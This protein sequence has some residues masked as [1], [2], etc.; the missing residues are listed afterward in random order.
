MEFFLAKLTEGGPS[1]VG[2]Y[3]WYVIVRDPGNGP[4]TLIA[5]AGYMGPPDP[6]GI[7][8]LGYSVAAE[9]RGRGYAI[10]TVRAL[11]GHALRD[12]AVRR[13]VART[14]ASNAA[15]RGV[16]AKC[17]F[18]P[19]DGRDEPV[20]VGSETILFQYNGDNPGGLVPPR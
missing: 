17:G 15:S 6:N 8:E 10:E 5:G 14:A 9:G 7:V 1:A 16:L 4:G 11:T 2:W 19:A 18:V 12:P 13:V 20:G 3:N